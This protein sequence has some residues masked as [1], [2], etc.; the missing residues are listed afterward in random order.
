MSTLDTPQPAALADTLFTQG[1]SWL[2]GF[3]SSLER[4]HLSEL[5]SL[6]KARELTWED[7]PEVDPERDWGFLRLGNIPLT[8]KD[9]QDVDLFDFQSILAALS[10][11]GDLQKSEGFRLAFLLTGKAG[12]YEL[13]LGVA[14]KKP[15]TGRALPAK[16]TVEQIAAITRSHLSGVN[17]RPEDE[18]GRV[19][20]LDRLANFERA[21][22]ITGIPTLRQGADRR[23]VQSLDRFASQLRSQRFALIILA[24]P[25]SDQHIVNAQSKLMDVISEL[26]PLVRAQLSKSTALQTA[27][28]VLKPSVARGISNVAENRIARIVGAGIMASVPGVLAIS[29]IKSVS[30]HVDIGSAIAEHGDTVAQGLSEIAQTLKHLPFVGA[31]VGAAVSIGMAALTRNES[32]SI[33]DSTGREQLNRKAQFAEE[34]LEAH[35]KRLMAGRNLGLWETGVFLLTND[36]VTDQLGASLLRALGSGA[37]THLE[38]MRVQYLTHT[39]QPARPVASV[40]SLQFPQLRPEVFGL[41]EA[42]PLGEQQQR[43]TTVLNTE[44][45]SIWMSLPQRDLPGISGR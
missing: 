40:Q 30:S 3:T 1:L 27:R 16:N 28:T 15:P 37:E 9:A 35:L 41:T 24:E 31:A 19:R 22:A 10:T 38:P 14:R 39:K 25:L 20:M 18:A 34:T 6:D 44:E 43:L 21:T 13:H 29:A 33:T 2:D 7:I 8:P 23:L 4:Q 5:T 26:H 36:E 45:L 17:T 11:L 42:H 12:Q 32:T